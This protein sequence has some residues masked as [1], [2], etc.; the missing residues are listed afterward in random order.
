MKKSKKNNKLLSEAIL[1]RIDSLIE[2]A[3]L[4]YPISSELSSQYIEL[5]FSLVKR[6]KVKLGNKKW[7]FCRKCFVPWR[8]E[9][10]YKKRSE[11][12]LIYECKICNYKRKRYFPKDEGSVEK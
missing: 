6:Y 1:C 8:E 4:V 7:L 3:H 5:A 2:I 12:F 9:T 10:V 11:E